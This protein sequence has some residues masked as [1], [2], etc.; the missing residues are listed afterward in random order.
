[1][2]KCSRLLERNIGI[3]P[4]RSNPPLHGY[5]GNMAGHCDGHQREPVGRRSAA[6][7]TPRL[8][9]DARVLAPPLTRELVYRLVMGAQGVR[10]LQ[11]AI[12]GALPTASPRPSSGCG[13]RLT[14]RCGSRTLRAS[15]G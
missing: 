14:S 7:P 10:L 4:H 1:M 3:L 6:R 8:P 9:S 13:T 2:Q 11:L 12:L 5:L 15:W